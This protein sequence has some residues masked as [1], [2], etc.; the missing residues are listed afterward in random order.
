MEYIGMSTTCWHAWDVSRVVE[1]SRC[2][3]VS[4][5]HVTWWTLEHFPRSR[6]RHDGDTQRTGRNSSNR[7]Y[8]RA[9]RSHSYSLDTAYIWPL[10]TFHETHYEIYQ[11]ASCPDLLISADFQLALTV[12]SAAH[13]RT[14]PG[15]FCRS[16][17]NMPWVQLLR[18][19]G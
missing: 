18:Y 12:F 3:W 13:V 1:S 5:Q 9:V 17:V 6:Q 14:Y 15:S 4:I 2:P 8:T 10:C 19:V 11:L 7:V 16:V